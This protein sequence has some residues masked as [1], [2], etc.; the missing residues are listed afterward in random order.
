MHVREDKKSINRT[1]EASKLFWKKLSASLHGMG[2]FPNPYNWCVM[3]KI[4]NG[5]KLMI[6]WHVDDLNISHVDPDVVL[7]TLMDINNHY[8]HNKVHPK[9][10]LSISFSSIYRKI[11][12]LRRNRTNS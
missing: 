7:D 10:S 9:I 11:F 12:I 2:F 5:K 4:I 8:I 6:L 3:N 1:L